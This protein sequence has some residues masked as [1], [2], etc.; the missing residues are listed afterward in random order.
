MGRV[1]KW[2]GL[3]ERGIYLVETHIDMECRIDVQ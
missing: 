3:I 1:D 2:A